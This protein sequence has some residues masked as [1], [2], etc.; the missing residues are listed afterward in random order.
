MGTWRKRGLR[1]SDQVDLEDSLILLVKCALLSGL[2]V[3]MFS[4]FETIAHVRVA[5]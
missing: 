2:G 5:D 1:E 4:R 3:W